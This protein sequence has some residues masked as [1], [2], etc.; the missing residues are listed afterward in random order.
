MM[1]NKNG[2]YDALPLLWI[3]YERT[4]L[5]VSIL[6]AIPGDCFRGQSEISSM[7]HTGRDIRFGEP[8]LP[9]GK[10]FSGDQEAGT[11]PAAQEL[12]FETGVTLCLALGVALIAQ[13]LLS[14]G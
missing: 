11:A 4:V 6:Y 13:L 7:L 2:R 3:L 12:C 10:S 9:N 8:A 1:D 5:A 14:G